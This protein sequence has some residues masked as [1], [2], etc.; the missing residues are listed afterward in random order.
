MEFVFCSDEFVFGLFYLYTAIAVNSA[1]DDICT[2]HVPM[3]SC[4]AY[5]THFFP[6]VGVTS[7]QPQLDTII[8]TVTT[9]QSAVTT[10]QA[11][12]ATLNNE[13]NV[14]EYDIW[15]ERGRTENEQR[16]FKDEMIKYYKRNAWSGNKLRCMVT[17]Q[18]HTQGDVIACHIWMNKTRGKGLV[19]FGLAVNDLMNTR[20][21]FLALKDIEDKFDRKQLCF[22]CSPLTDSGKFLV[23]VLD[24]N[25]IRNSVVRNSNPRSSHLWK[26]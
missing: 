8:S 24:P 16:S 13:F 19:K 21:G 3:I 10:L 26:R 7:S 23:K 4:V 20:N 2:N 5:F 17:N 1:P 15:T 22:L 14:T 9:L 18:W 11:T 25:S 6:N 12:V